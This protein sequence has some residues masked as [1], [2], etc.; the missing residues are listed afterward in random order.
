MADAAVDATDTSD[1]KTKHYDAASVAK[2]SETPENC[3]KNRDLDGAMG[4]HLTNGAPVNPNTNREPGYH[5]TTQYQPRTYRGRGVGYK[6][7]HPN[8]SYHTRSTFRPNIRPFHRPY[9]RPYCRPFY[10]QRIQYYPR[11]TRSSYHRPPHHS[12]PSAYQYWRTRSVWVQDKDAR[13]NNSQTLNK[14]FNPQKKEEKFLKEDKKLSKPAQLTSAYKKS[15]LEIIPEDRPSKVVT[16]E[17]GVRTTPIV[18]IKTT[19]QEDRLLPLALSSYTFDMVY[20]QD[21]P[22]LIRGE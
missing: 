9:N 15:F 12:R 11:K 1:I 2:N 18:S 19:A 4:E 14:I 21:I 8:T 20:Y 17:K 22:V 7:H 13:A 6:H 3:H 5:S 10:Q 16:S